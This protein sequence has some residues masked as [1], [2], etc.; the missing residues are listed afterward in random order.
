[1]CAGRK[2]SARLQIW[3]VQ[4]DEITDWLTPEMNARFAVDPWFPS[5][6]VIREVGITTQNI[7]P[8][9]RNLAG[10]NGVIVKNIGMNLQKMVKKE[11]SSSVFSM[12]ADRGEIRELLYQASQYLSRSNPSFNAGESGRNR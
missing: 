6:E 11:P 7:T 10:G 3:I 2:D 8:G 12:A 5:F 9:H 1:M 4:N